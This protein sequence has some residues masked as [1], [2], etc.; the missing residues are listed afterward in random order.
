MEMDAALVTINCEL[1]LH[2]TLSGFQSEL[3][4]QQIIEDYKIMFWNFIFTFILTFILTLSSS[5]ENPAEGPQRSARTTTARKRQLLRTR[6]EPCSIHRGGSAQ[7]RKYGTIIVAK[8]LSNVSLN[9]SV[10][11]QI[12]E[13]VHGSANLYWVC[14]CLNRVENVCLCVWNPICKYAKIAVTE[15]D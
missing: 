15:L 8:L 9:T 7:E 5:V 6:V 1:M 3:L 4:P 14:V 2:F 12:C 11:N 10:C 13:C